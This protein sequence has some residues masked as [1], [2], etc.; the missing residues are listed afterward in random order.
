MHP[1]ATLFVDVCVQRDFWPDGGWPLVSEAEAAAIARLCVLAAELGVRRHGIVCLH[2]VGASVAGGVP[3]HCAVGLPGSARPAAVALPPPS[4][5]ADSAT[6]CEGTPDDGPPFARAVAGIRDAVVFGA[7]VE[8]GVT[9]AVDALLRRRI[10]THVALDAVAAAD[11]DVA[12]HV[13]AAWKRRGVDG[14][15]VATIE[16]LLRAG[17]RN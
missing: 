11:A 10:R 4:A 15:T 14:A 6:G 1:P 8:Y 12:Q 16:R 17:T 13:V 5:T 9:R 3:A 7:G 2:G